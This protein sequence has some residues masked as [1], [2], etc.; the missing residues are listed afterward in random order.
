MKGI[1]P[2]P[3]RTDYP[4]VWLSAGKKAPG[5]LDVVGQAELLHYDKISGNTDVAI[6]TRASQLIDL[7]STGL[8]I[9]WE[10]KKVGQ[11]DKTAEFQAACQLVLANVLSSQLQPVVVLTD[12]NEKWQVLWMD[13]NTVFVGVC[14]SRCAAVSVIQGCMRQAEVLATLPSCQ[15]LG[16]GALP[17]AP[18][19]QLPVELAKRRSALFTIPPQP[20]DR[21][22]ELDGFLPQHELLEAR[23][24]TALQQ[25]RRIPVFAGMLHGDA[26]LPNSTMF[27]LYT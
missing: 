1:V 22:D 9:L 6:V 13:G 18:G 17:S 23:A 10:L 14:P 2:L 20:D 25:L 11:V 24:L 15:P 3:S 19:M 5:L 12:L 4:L 27:S 16:G 21:L 7:P 8:C 26:A